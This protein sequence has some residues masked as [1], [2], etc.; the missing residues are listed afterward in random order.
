MT[1]LSFLRMKN[2]RLG[3]ATACCRAPSDAARSLIAYG[4]GIRWRVAECVLGKPG[5]G[6]RNNLTGIR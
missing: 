6:P 5:D 4:L 2:A 1:A 3:A